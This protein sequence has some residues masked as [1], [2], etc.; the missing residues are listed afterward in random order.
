[1]NKI[2]TDR[3]LTYI[4]DSFKN[5][6]IQF[7]IQ[8][9]ALKYLIDCYNLLFRSSKT[10]Q[11][12]L[13]SIYQE[14]RHQILR[15]IILVLNGC[16]HKSTYNLSESQL[17]PFLMANY[18]STDLINQLIIESA[19]TSSKFLKSSAQFKNDFVTVIF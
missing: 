15:N 18:V 13:E 16:Y 12:L 8:S 6:N 9:I 10:D 5:M 17:V 2:L 3:S 14:S 7:T 11:D 19:K 4:L 1:M